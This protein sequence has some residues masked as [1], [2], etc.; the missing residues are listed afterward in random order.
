LFEDRW[1]YWP[2]KYPSG[3]WAAEDHSFRFED[4]SFPSADGTGLHGWLASRSL[5]I[6]VQAAPF[7][8]Y[9]HGSAGNITYRSPIIARLLEIDLTLFIFDYR[10]FGKSAG[11]A[12]EAG[13]RADARAAYDHVRH[14]MGVAAE[15]LFLFGESLGV[16]VAASLA[17]EVPCAGL[18]LHGGLTDGWD[19][20]TLKMPWLPRFLLQRLTRNQFDARSA[21]AKCG[22]PKLF[23]HGQKDSLVPLD[24]A[25]RL[26]EA[27]AEPKSWFEVPGLGHDDFENLGVDYVCR[28]RQF[29][30]AW[31]SD[32]RSTSLRQ[33]SGEDQP[34]EPTYRSKK[35]ND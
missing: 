26:Y 4:V 35:D 18:I 6:G 23:V 2:L 29:L 12:T 11:T 24:M 32:N 16:A 21:V 13:L 10:G 27:A 34:V 5:N 17:C 1:I 33:P 25:R 28:L 31:S 7:L 15:R 3:R 19:M 30:E 20:A 22:K 9:C 14:R 8:L